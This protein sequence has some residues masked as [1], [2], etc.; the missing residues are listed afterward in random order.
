MSSLG[1]ST[2]QPAGGMGG[3][4]P[5]LDPQP[6]QSGCLQLDAFAEIDQPLRSQPAILYIFDDIYFFDTFIDLCSY[7]VRP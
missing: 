3:A 6:T 4:G 1:R 7:V 2:G 5:S